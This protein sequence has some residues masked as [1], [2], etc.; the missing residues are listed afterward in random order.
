MARIELPD[1]IRR[2]T[3]E[4]RRNYD[5]PDPRPQLTAG[6]EYIPDTSK[7]ATIRAPGK[8][9]PDSPITTAVLEVPGHVRRGEYMEAFN[10]T[11]DAITEV[12]QGVHVRGANTPTYVFKKGR[13]TAKIGDHDALSKA[14]DRVTVMNREKRMRK[15]DRAARKIQAIDGSSGFT[16]QRSYK[17]SRTYL[18]LETFGDAFSLAEIL[19]DGTKIYNVRDDA[20]GRQAVRDVI[21]DHLGVN[22]NPWCLASGNMAATPGTLNSAAEGHWRDNSRFQ[23]QIVVDKAGKIEAFAAAPGNKLVGADKQLYW[24]L[25]DTPFLSLHDLRHN[26]ANRVIDEFT[27]LTAPEEAARIDA[28][29]NEHQAALVDSLLRANPS[30]PREV[31]IEDVRRTPNGEAYVPN[32]DFNIPADLPEP[33]PE[34]LTNMAS[35]GGNAPDLRGISNFLAT[36]KVPD[37]IFGIPV[38]SRRDSYSEKDIAFFKEHPEAGGYYDMGD[39]NEDTSSA[40]EVP[41]QGMGEVQPREPFG[42]G[43]PQMAA[44]GGKTYD[45]V[46]PKEREAE[47]LAWRATLPKPLQYEG[48]YDLRGYWMDP[49]TKKTAVTGDHF[50]DK[51]KKPNHPTFSVESK[52]AVGADANLAGTWNGETYIPNPNA[53]RELWNRAVKSTGN[54]DGMAR[55]FAAM[56]GESSLNQRGATAE[57]ISN[58]HLARLVIHANET[59]RYNGN[60]ANSGKRSVS[61][62]TN[63][64]SHVLSKYKWGTGPGSNWFDASRMEPRFDLINRNPVSVETAKALIMNGARFLNGDLR[65]MD[66]LPADAVSY[67]DGPKG[68]MPDREEIRQEENRIGPMP[69]GFRI[70]RKKGT[71]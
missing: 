2:M 47:Y 63:R 64:T 50:I 6:P 44:K 65:G 38:V 33:P 23:K 8:Q 53:I 60:P 31:L 56:S 24:D 39:E 35:K 7:G 57:Q 43:I 21:N 52:Y 66:L 37:T 19:P 58:G 40:E 32:L 68:L 4:M 28:L 5:N 45:T 22:A 3:A 36:D 14:Q 17:N 16:G 13:V 59:D 25:Q 30:L 20:V 27:G 26:R 29:R 12:G 70:G 42:E 15:A 48:D 61:D 49:D 51:Y 41:A 11:L 18:A 54:L 46:I 67:G 1:D 71:K 62:T 10:K 34:I 9:I 55:V 69:K